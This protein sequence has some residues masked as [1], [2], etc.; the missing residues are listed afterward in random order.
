MAKR[1]AGRPSHGLSETAVLVRL[2]QSLLEDVTEAAS[3]SGEK[4]SE[5]I[6]EALR[7]RVVAQLA[8]AA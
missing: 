7:R 1:K 8:E 2:P 5:W 6:R 4:R 3:L